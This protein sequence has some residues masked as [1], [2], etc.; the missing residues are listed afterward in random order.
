MLLILATI[1][2]PQIMPIL[3]IL[4]LVAVWTYRKSYDKITLLITIPTSIIGIIIGAILVSQVNQ[5][6]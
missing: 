6:G 5:T 2:N 4:D 1:V 3:L